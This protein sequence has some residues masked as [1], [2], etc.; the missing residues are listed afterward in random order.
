MKE[1]INVDNENSEALFKLMRYNATFAGNQMVS[2][3]DY[4]AKMKP[5]QEKIYFVVSPSLENAIASPF[6]ESFKADDAP[7]VLILTNNIDEF[8]F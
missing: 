7:P 4:I 6:M 1:G 3:D 5:G 2:L 8:S